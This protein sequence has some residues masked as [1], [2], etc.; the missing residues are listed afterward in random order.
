MYVSADSAQEVAVW[1][2]VLYGL[3]QAGV[4]QVPAEVPNMWLRC[5]E[6]TGNQPRGRMTTLTLT[7]SLPGYEQYK[8]IQIVYDI[9]NG[10]QDV[11]VH[12]Y[13]VNIFIIA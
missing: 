4:R 10:I 5:G 8:T 1:P 12:V 9:P 2:F 13:I 3:H 11:S 7:S 6:M